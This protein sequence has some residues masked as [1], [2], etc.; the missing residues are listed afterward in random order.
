MGVSA[1]QFDRI[2][3]RKARDPEI[4]WRQVADIGNILRHQYQ[5]AAPD[6]RWRVAQD[7]PPPPEHVCRVELA[8]A[9]S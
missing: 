3:L 8:T 2:M 4:P 6:V 5:R 7:D 9:G 1:V